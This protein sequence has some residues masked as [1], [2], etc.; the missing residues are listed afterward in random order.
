LR[1]F[2]GWLIGGIG[3]NDAFVTP[4][5]GLSIGLG[6]KNDYTLIVGTHHISQLSIYNDHLENKLYNLIAII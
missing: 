1:G 4:F 6:E 5:R 2:G 3:L